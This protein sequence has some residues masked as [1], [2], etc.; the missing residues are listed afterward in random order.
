MAYV[1]GQRSKEI[2]VRMALGATAG[3]V[4]WLM[5]KRGVNLA[6]I[7]LA[8]GVAGAIVAGRLVRGMLF[9]VQPHDVPTYV[10]VVALLGL[11][12]LCATYVPARRAT[13]VDPVAVL[14]QE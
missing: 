4:L 6:A 14:R 2:G 5:L 11:L 9:D 3:S 12:S 13:R 7:G 1:A 10:G 8:A